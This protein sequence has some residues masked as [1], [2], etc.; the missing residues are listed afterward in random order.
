MR[1]ARRLA[2]HGAQ[3][4]TFRGIVTRGAQT[5][6]IERHDLRAPPLQEQFA[7]VGPGDGLAQ[8]T[9]RRVLIDKRLEGAE[10]CALGHRG[11]SFHWAPKR[12]NAATRSL[13]RT[14]LI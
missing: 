8:Q 7:I 3:A 9:K 13:V 11:G 14:P 4:K 12:R 6:V 10:I 5:P 1:I 2:P